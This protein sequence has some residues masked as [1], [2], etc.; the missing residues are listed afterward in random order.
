MSIYIVP[1]TISF[2]SI[3]QARQIA[4]QMYKGN[5]SATTNLRQLVLIQ[6]RKPQTI[7][8]HHVSM[9]YETWTRN[10]KSIYTVYSI[11]VSKNLII[12]QHTVINVVISS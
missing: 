9:V 12:S 2:T 7:Q 10:L 8:L 6:S 11:T 3:F 4:V 5:T 1:G